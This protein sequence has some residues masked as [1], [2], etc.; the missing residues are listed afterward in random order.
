[1]SRKAKELSIFFDN[2]NY[3]NNN[4]SGSQTSE[5]SGE[6]AVTVIVVGN[7][8]NDGSVGG[9][10]VHLVQNS[11]FWTG[12][13]AGDDFLDPSRVEYID[14]RSIFGFETTINR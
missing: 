5:P 8:D 1:M 4:G 11:K 2:D 3:D 14:K 7:V 12:F 10:I 9:H 6:G 13:G